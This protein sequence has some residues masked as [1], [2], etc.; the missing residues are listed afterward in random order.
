MRK[1]IWLIA[2]TVSICSCKKEYKGTV[3]VNKYNHDN[4]CPV[5]LYREYY[6]MFSGYQTT[7]INAV[8][9][10]DSTNFRLYLWEYDESNEHINT[11]C[12]GDS[13]YVEKT[14][15]TSEIPEWNWPKIIERKVYDLKELQ[16]QHVFE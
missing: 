16:K 13:L 11:T 1:F 3:A 8:Y 15:N 6:C 7:D 10:T 9:L 14:V 5:K 12:K 2:I 4:G